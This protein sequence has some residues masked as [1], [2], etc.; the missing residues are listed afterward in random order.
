MYYLKQKGKS[1][2]LKSNSCQQINCRLFQDSDEAK[3]QLAFHNSKMGRT[4]NFVVSS[5]ESKIPRN[6]GMLIK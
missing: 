6:F 5:Q 2:T 1:K 4:D 3:P